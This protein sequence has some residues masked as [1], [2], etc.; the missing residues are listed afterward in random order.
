MEN[1]IKMD[2]LGVPLF[3]ETPIYYQVLLLLVSG[4]GIINEAVSPLHKA[5]LILE[6]QGM[7]EGVPFGWILFVERMY[8]YPLYLA[9]GKLTW[10]LLANP[11]SLSMFHTQSSF[12]FH[13]CPCSS[14]YVN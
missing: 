5:L 3:L 7:L 4:G 14:S 2:G 6:A 13:V 9:S 11:L 1:I 8:K 10:R 12:I